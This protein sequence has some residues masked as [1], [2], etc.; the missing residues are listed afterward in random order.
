MIRAFVGIGVP[1]PLAATLTAAQ[2]GLEVGNPVP[3]ENFH[4]TL[5]FLGEQREPVVDEMAD[6]LS[7]IAADTFDV[8]IAGLG[9]FGAAPRILFAEVA[10]SPPLSALRKRVRRAAAECGIDLPSERFRP[11]VTLARMGRGLVGEDA[12]RLHHHIARRMDWFAAPFGPRPSR[13][14]NRISVAPGRS[15][16]RW[17]ST[18]CAPSERT[19]ATLLSLVCGPFFW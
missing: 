12:A 7:G 8:V 16:R 15:T 19:R 6:A 5:A 2:A 18:R 4:L 3:A 14:T 13:S 1:E 9:T 11:H 10:V 17:P